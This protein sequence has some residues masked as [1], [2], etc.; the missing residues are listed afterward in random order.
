MARPAHTGSHRDRLL[1]YD[2]EQDSPL[3]KDTLF[4]AAVGGQVLPRAQTPL[5]EQ[6][7]CLHRRV[8]PA[9]HVLAPISAFRSRQLVRCRL[10]SANVVP[11]S[12][13]R[14]QNHVAV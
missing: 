13:A 9:A 2:P 12:T 11:S 4:V 3:C 14:R 5:S 1:V 8:P 6:Q 10:G 7:R